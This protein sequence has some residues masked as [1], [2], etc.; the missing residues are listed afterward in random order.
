[1]GPPPRPPATAGGGGAGHQAERGRHASDVPTEG[2]QQHPKEQAKNDE[3]GGSQGSKAWQTMGRVLKELWR[4]GG[5]DIVVA[6]RVLRTLMDLHQ[7][8]GE[9][10]GG[11]A[12][13]IPRIEQRF[14]AL[15]RRILDLT[16]R[17]P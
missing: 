7:E 12:T 9:A 17:I 2:E 10:Q 1:M 16:K 3:N 6:P 8:M 5:A 15:E 11:Q 13:G 14:D 4:D